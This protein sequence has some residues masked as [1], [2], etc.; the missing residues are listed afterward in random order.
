MRVATVLIGMEVDFLHVKKTNKK[1]NDAI[2]WLDFVMHL[3]S[4]YGKTIRCCSIDPT[5]SSLWYILLHRRDDDGDDDNQFTIKASAI[6]KI[7]KK[8]LCTM[9]LDL[10]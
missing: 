7:T 3:H 6:L 1:S 10:W 8:N 4:C 2:A 5:T 9:E